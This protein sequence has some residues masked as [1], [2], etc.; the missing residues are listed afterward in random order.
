MEKTSHLNIFDFD[1]TLFRVPSYASSEAKGLEPYLWFDS[2]DSLASKFPIRGI[3]NTIERIEQDCI[4]V[5]I[6]HR[7]KA[8][9]S[10]VLDILA[11]HDIRFDKTFFLGRD[12]K[13]A[14]LAVNLIREFE[15]DSISIFEDS[16]WEIIQYTKEFLDSGLSIDIEF[17]F[18][19]KSKIIR[20]DWDSARSL[21]EFSETERLRII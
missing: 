10:R 1:E 3:A 4:N 5:M 11:D 14:E 7:V 21:E 18:V 19:D 9:Q 8:C 20:I 13:K 16:L 2:P 15:I 17:F 6:T 12:S